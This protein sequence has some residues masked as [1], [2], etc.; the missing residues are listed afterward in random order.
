M[1][2][3]HTPT[4]RQARSH[5]VGT[6]KPPGTWRPTLPGPY[7][8]LNALDPLPSLPRQATT[9]T[10]ERPSPCLPR[11]AGTSGTSWRSSIAMWSFNR[12]LRLFRRLS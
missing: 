6:R 10:F 9:V 8:S 7:S 4:T 2:C 12:S 1:N 11:Y 5:P 3:D